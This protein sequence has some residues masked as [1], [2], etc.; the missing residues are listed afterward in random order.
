MCSENICYCGHDCARCVVYLATVRDDDGL[1]GQAQQFY[2]KEFGR[3]LPLSEI[4]CMGG[5]SGAV[6][7]LCA[8]CPW[9]RCC[10]ERGIEA[11]VQCDAYPCVPLAEYQKRYVDKCNQ[12]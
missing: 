6:L 11:C 7:S 3:E 1:R 10:R 4:H 9:A 12:I 8:E 5:R 2:K